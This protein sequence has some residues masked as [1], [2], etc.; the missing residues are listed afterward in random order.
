MRPEQYA[1]LEYLADKIENDPYALSDEEAAEF[2]VLAR[3]LVTYNDMLKSK[4]ILRDNE[5]ALISVSDQLNTMW[6]TDFTPD[7]VGERAKEI[8]AGRMIVVQCAPNPSTGQPRFIAIPRNPALSSQEC[9]NEWL[10]NSP[11]GLD[12]L[13][14]EKNNGLR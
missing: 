12:R 8:Q 7:E 13:Q 2:E 9:Y 5:L 1:R 14:W 10:H 4:A 11:E 3:I 6:G